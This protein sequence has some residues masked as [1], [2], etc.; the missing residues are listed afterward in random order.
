MEPARINQIAASLRGSPDRPVN[1]LEHRAR[2]IHQPRIRLSNPAWLTVFA[3][4]ALTAIGA[5]CIQISSSLTADGLAPNAL[6]QAVFAVVGVVVAAIVALPHTRRVVPM[7]WPIYAAVVFLLVFL[8]IPFVPESIVRSRN[9]SRRWIDVGFTEFQPS[10]LAKIAFVLALAGWLRFRS[11]HRRILGLFVPSVIAFVPMALI[12]VEPDLGTSLLFLPTLMAMLVA[13]GARMTHLISALVLGLGFAIAVGVLSLMFAARGEYPLLRPHQV[14]RIQAVVDQVKGDDRFVRE[15]GFQGR[16]AQTLVGAGGLV[17]HPE[18]RS[19]ALIHFSALPERHNDMVFAV[20]ANRFGLVGIAGLLGLYGLWILGALAAAA[21]SKDPFG[22]L[23]AVGF[24]AMVF[25]QTTI[26]IGMT[27][28]LLP[29]T[30]M[31]LPF[32]S[33]GGSSLVA[34]FIMVGLVFSVAVRR[35]QYLWR[36]SFEFDPAEE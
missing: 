18:E 2:A 20:F 24:A 19:R 23:I 6:R 12:L 33:Y 29:I 3:S 26:N 35:P 11:H 4:L 9:G 28:G 16:Q 34:S 15:R 1:A 27:V 36:R 8:L 13:A 17:G 32:V 7:V 31:T 25:T 5:Y 14:E 21:Q 30:G 10:E 22:R